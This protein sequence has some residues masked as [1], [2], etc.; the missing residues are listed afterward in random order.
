[1]NNE[2]NYQRLLR[3]SETQAPYRGSDNR[4][5]FSDR[6]Y[7]HKYFLKEIVNG[8]PQFKLSYWYGQD[9]VSEPHVFGIVRSDNTIEFVL[10]RRYMYQGLRQIMSANHYAKGYFSSSVKHGGIIY[11]KFTPTKEDETIKEWRTIPIFNGLRMNIDTAEIHENSKYTFVKKTLNRKKSQ[12]LL[13]RYDNAFKVAEVMFVN[14]DRDKI[15]ETKDEIGKEYFPQCW[16]DSGNYSYLDTTE[17]THEV[18]QKANSMLESSPFDAF[19][20]FTV[21]H[22][23]W[24]RHNLNIKQCFDVAKKR[25]FKSMQ[26]MNDV[27]NV[28]E[29]DYTQ[30]M[31]AS[32]WSL[33]VKVNNQLVKRYH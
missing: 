32:V 15:K 12:A 10:E 23:M 8:E 26:S 25:I 31:P 27:F 6:R 14:L 20:L 33:D 24:W 17:I 18:I 29:Y 1:M 28:K 5:P 22:Q 7:G 19:I 13:D 21:A 4:F 9:P 3:I 16:V 2:F 11:R 30:N